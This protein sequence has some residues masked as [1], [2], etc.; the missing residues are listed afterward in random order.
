MTDA[1][2]ATGTGMRPPEGSRIMRRP[3]PIAVDRRDVVA[4]GQ[5]C[6]GACGGACTNPGIPPAPPPRAV[7][8]TRVL[9]LMGERLAI[10]CCHSLS[11]SSTG[12]ACKQREARDE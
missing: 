8:A 1:G 6:G 7:G 4:D 5:T 3:L 12:C 2:S 11:S 9:L 10:R